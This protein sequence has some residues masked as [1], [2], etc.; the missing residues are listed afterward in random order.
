LTW[1]VTVAVVVVLTVVTVSVWW[2]TAE[3][4]LRKPLP[5]GWAILVTGLVVVVSVIPALFAPLGYEVSVK[6]IVIR[7]LGWNVAI[8]LEAIRDVCRVKSE[9]TGFTW[10]LWASGGF[11]GWF[12][13]FYN[14]GL[15]EFWAYVGNRRDLVLLTQADGTKI[16]I[17]PHPLGA[18]LEAVQKAGESEHLA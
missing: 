7:R 12:G 10:R 4:A 2:A 1:I 13:L 14:R 11:L 15:G 9:E 18:F 16:V 6:A 3:V 17:S 5:V 8:P